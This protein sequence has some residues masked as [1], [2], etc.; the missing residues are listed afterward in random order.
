MSKKQLF[1]S[2][3]FY[4]TLIK[5]YQNGTEEATLTIVIMKKNSLLLFQQKECY[6]MYKPYFYFY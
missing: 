2:Y 1:T 5:V 6:Y 4:K 3:A